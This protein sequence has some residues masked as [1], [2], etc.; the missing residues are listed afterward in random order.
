VEQVGLDEAA[1]VGGDEGPDRRVGPPELEVCRSPR[2]DTA[3]RHVPHAVVRGAVGAGHPAR[4][5]T[6]GDPGTVHRAVHQQLVEGAV[7]ERRI[8]RHDRVQAGERQTGGHR[9]RVLLGDADVERA[10][11]VGVAEVLEADG[12]HHRGGD[13]DDVLTLATTDAHHLVG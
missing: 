10:L 13:G 11:G 3:D 1:L 7:E 2:H 12:D 4:S 5:S 8:D 6:N 9:Q